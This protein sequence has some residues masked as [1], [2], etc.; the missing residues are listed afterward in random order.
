MVLQNFSNSVFEL[1]DAARDTAPCE[2]HKEIMRIVGKLISFDGAIFGAGRRTSSAHTRLMIDRAHVYSS[3]EQPPGDYADIFSLDPVVGVLMSALS[4]PATVDCRELNQLNKI[5]GLERF[6]VE[7]GLQ[8]MLLFGDISQTNDKT[9]WIALYRNTKRNFTK[10]DAEILQAIWRHVACTIEIN[11][12][13][14]LAQL[15]PHNPKPAVALIN[16]RGVIEAASK[17]LTE[18]MQLEWPQFD[19]CHLPLPVIVELL[20]NGYYRGRA[21]EITA[22]QKFGYLAC[23]AKRKTMLDML[24]PSELVVADR[25]A[26]GM[27]H[28]EIAAHLRVSPYTVRNQIAQVYQKLGIHSKVELAHIMFG[29]QA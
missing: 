18:V 26:K 17:F 13:Q 11:L 14:A 16:S 20:N 22:L 10:P 25:F 5:E 21:I 4:E 27:T 8:E 3:P 12:S 29:R 2:F 24:A 6:I 23:T 9:R 15:E 19:T 28:S 1:Y 7:H